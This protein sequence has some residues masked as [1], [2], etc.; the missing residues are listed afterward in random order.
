VSSSELDGGRERFLFQSTIVLP[1]RLTMSLAGG[2]EGRL[3]S[4]TSANPR[5]P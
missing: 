2:S 1:P 3:R 5:R 4:F